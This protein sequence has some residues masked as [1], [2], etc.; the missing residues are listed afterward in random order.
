MA[1]LIDNHMPSSMTN[2]ESV[3]SAFANKSDKLILTV[4]SYSKTLPIWCGNAAD[5]VVGSA[6]RLRHSK[7]DDLFASR[8]CI[9]RYSFES[10]YTI[11]LEP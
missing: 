2:C 11:P 1:R 10:F 3:D 4:I 5:D 6:G 8:R 7:P 9:R